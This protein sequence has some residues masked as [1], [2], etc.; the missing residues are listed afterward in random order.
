MQ[1]KNPLD[2]QRENIIMTAPKEDLTLMLYDGC[3]KFINQAILAVEKKDFLKANELCIKA[4]NIILEFRA[5]LDTSFEISTQMDVM[6]V[7]IYERLIQ[8]NMKKDLALLAEAR[9]L[10]RSFRDSWKEAS[11][12]SRKENAGKPPTNQDQTRRGINI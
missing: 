11:A 7:Y 9:D 4:Q 2:K 3:L 1:I 8:G 12:L 10:V 5:T 6:Y